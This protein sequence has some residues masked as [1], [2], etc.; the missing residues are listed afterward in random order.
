MS[1]IL[2]YYEIEREN[3]PK[4]TK[5]NWQ[6]LE[7]FLTSQNRKNCKNLIQVYQVEL[8]S[9]FRSMV[10]SFFYG[11]ISL[12][13]AS[14]VQVMLY[15]LVPISCLS[16][17]IRGYLLIL[18]Y[19]NRR[20]YEPF[21]LSL[22]EFFGTMKSKGKSSFFSKLIIVNQPQVGIPPPL[23]P[24]PRKTDLVQEKKD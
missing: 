8:N 2:W 7:I 23:P 3:P 12:C 22:V 11:L 24:P 1:Q 6:I 5:I 17:C 10:H 21:L 13:Y 15:R 19:Q 4:N 14:L 9:M 18:S 16:D 20:S